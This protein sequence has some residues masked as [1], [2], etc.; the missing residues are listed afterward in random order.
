MRDTSQRLAPLFFEVG[1]LNEEEAAKVA[2]GGEKTLYAVLQSDVSLQTFKDLFTVDLLAPFQKS[3]PKKMEGELYSPL[4]ISADEIAYLMH[5]NQREVKPLLE[6]LAE[7]DLLPRKRLKEFEEMAS[8]VSRSEI[9]LALEGGYITP[10][11]IVKLVIRG[12]DASARLS[13]VFVAV[14]LLLY[15]RIVSRK[16]AQE[17]IDLFSNKD[18]P[19][20][21]TLRK[22][23]AYDPE[24]LVEAIRKGLYF[25]TVS[26]SQVQ[27]PEALLAR[28]PESLLRHE[29]F[30]PF[31]R[32]GQTIRIALPDPLHFA[33]CDL[34]T[35]LTGM[36]VSPHFA[37]HEEVLGT[38]AH[39]F[40]PGSLRSPR[41]ITE[42][43]PDLPSRPPSRR[44]AK[45]PAREMPKRPKTAP[46]HRP[47]T[48]SEAAAPAPR[49]TTL[50]TSRA[51]IRE[52]SGPVDSL[53]AV[54][55]VSSMVETAVAARATDIHVEPQRQDTRVR[56]RI[57]GVLHN[58]MTIPED[59][60]LACVS[61]IKVLAN[62]NVT[63]RRRPQDGHF[64][65][66]I[67]ANS[68]DF[69][70]SI[71]PSH[72]GEKVVIRILDASSMSKGIGDLGMWPEQVKE[73]ESTLE[74]PHGLILAVGPTGA[75]KTSTLYAILRA[76][77][78]EAV[79]IVTLEDP[80][81]YELPGITQIQADPNL[82]LG[83]ASGLRSILRQDPDIIMVGEV[84]D[85]ETARIAVRAAITGHLVLSTLHTN[86][87]VGA[88][89]TLRQMGIPTYLMG[90]ALLA[91]ISQRL[92]RR[93]CPHC[94]T[95]R[96][97][98]VVRLRSVSIEPEQ[99]ENLA[100]G[101]GCDHCFQSGFLGRHGV[102]EVL[103]LSD[104]LKR[105]VLSNASEQDLTEIAGQNGMLFIQDSAR[106]AV[107]EGITTPE[108][109]IEVLLG[110]T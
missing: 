80:I 88:V 77:N 38:I 41:F 103:V 50:A 97:P 21:E 60:T 11:L 105:A 94:K 95:T 10:D 46:P 76:L 99:V 92:I 32:Q 62:M 79:N 73:I 81:E 66:E 58:A 26:L 6:E 36:W 52:P 63:E 70:V 42:T 89:S 65:L 9:D 53:S 3:R 22:R 20:P 30:V 4:T 18:I 29:G 108:E 2:P 34:I 37:P 93:I 43:S 71:L 96:D 75:G 47:P 27:V 90:A 100:E 48:E 45:S 40:A 44:P 85:E 72:Y 7:A 14:D 51:F 49:P 33:L 23:K 1:F 109:I 5:E 59:L 87:A 61:R 101:K 106:R 110:A 13:H 55:L 24:Q 12:K 15:N 82:N 16:E 56:L 102:F 86:T 25:P 67:A 17:A 19:V 8:S 83:F 54:R 28:F 91:V 74:F 98:D 69:R 31:R 104:K 68:Y 78:K 64:S 35:I 107:L 57:D 39:L 84:R